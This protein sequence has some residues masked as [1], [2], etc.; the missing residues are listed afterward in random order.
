MG[1]E[2]ECEIARPL[3][4]EIDRNLWEKFKNKVSRNISLNEAVVSLIKKD[5]EENE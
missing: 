4:L 1:D 5:V 3:T 2:K